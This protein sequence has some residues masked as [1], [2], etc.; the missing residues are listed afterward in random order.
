MG[1]VANQNGLFYF[2]VPHGEKYHPF[3]QINTNQ[4]K[5]DAVSDSGTYSNEK[6]QKS[7]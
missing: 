1:N 7:F 4:Y 5:K 3:I 6:R 2:F